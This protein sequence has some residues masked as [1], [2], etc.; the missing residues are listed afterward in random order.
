MSVVSA[1]AEVG[2]SR[3]SLGTDLDEPLAL[4]LADLAQD[5]SAGA[6]TRVIV[7]GNRH[8]TGAKFIKP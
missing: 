4:L 7:G 2:G 8:N 6:A 1:K 5:D 3:V